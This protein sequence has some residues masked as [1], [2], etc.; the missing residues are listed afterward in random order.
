M[1]ADRNW[2]YVFIYMY[3]NFLG[4][5]FRF[6]FFLFSF[7]FSSRFLSNRSRSQVAESRGSRLSSSKRFLYFF[8]ITMSQPWIKWMAC[9][10]TENHRS[11]MNRQWRDVFGGEW[12]NTMHYHWTSVSLR[13]ISMIFALDI[14]FCVGCKPSN[15]TND[16]IFILKKYHF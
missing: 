6:S 11:K 15:V 16:V 5:I 4:L 14:L 13:S 9:I 3:M 8:I 7:F 12:K 2:P 10:R 1:Y